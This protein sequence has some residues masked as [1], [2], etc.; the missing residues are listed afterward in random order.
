MCKYSIST[1]YFTFFLLSKLHLF[2][3]CVIPACVLRDLILKIF[4][5]T[6]ATHF[7]IERRWILYI[8]KGKWPLSITSLKNKVLD[9]Y[10]S[11]YLA[12]LSRC[13]TS[14]KTLFLERSINDSGK[15]N[16]WSKTGLLELTWT[17]VLR[18][19]DDALFLTSS[20]ELSHNDT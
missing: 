18:S 16:V 8:K 4:F 11:T 10:Y 2:F 7:L 20:T 12:L 5:R 15:W 19:G 13:Q 6:L 1:W 17:A 3:L 14:I 9:F